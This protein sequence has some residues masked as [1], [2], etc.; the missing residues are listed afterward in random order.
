MGGN[1][2]KRIDEQGN[3]S[4]IC[5]VKGGETEVINLFNGQ[6]DASTVSEESPRFYVGRGDG[7]TSTY[8]PVSGSLSNHVP[9]IDGNGITGL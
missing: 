7:I 2:L 4:R 1:E 6:V 5:V 9:I 8:R 3:T